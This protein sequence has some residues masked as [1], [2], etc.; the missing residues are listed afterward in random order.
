MAHP[1][2]ASTAANLSF[3]ATQWLGGNLNNIKDEAGVDL[4]FQIGVG[5][6]IG[7]VIYKITS[8]M[9]RFILVRI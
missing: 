8:R 7:K 4:F 5:M 9:E 2:K 3:E 1:T 6:G